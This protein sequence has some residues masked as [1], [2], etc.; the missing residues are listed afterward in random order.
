MLM[1]VVTP[2]NDE[3]YDDEDDDDDSSIVSISLLHVSRKAVT[4]M[5]GG[6][7]TALIT[8]ITPLVVK[9]SGLTTVA[10]SF[11]FI[12]LD[13]E[14]EDKSISISSPCDNVGTDTVPIFYY[15]TMYNVN[16]MTINSTMKRQWYN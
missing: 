1:M 15:D 3:M 2:E 16:E 14:D 4:S 11:N 6:T 10:E 9:I 12:T 5:D 13:I 7:K 8:C